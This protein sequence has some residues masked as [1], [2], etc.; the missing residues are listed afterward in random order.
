MGFK[1]TAAPVDSTWIFNPLERTVIN[2][3]MLHSGLEPLSALTNGSGAA[4]ALDG[5]QFTAANP[6][7]ARLQT[8]TTDTGRAGLT[9]IIHDVGGGSIFTSVI[10][11]E[12]LATVG[13]DYEVEVGWGNDQAGLEHTDGYYFRYKRSVSANWYRC[14]NDDD[15]A[16]RTDTSVAVVAD[17]YIKL[18]IKVNAARTAAEFFINGTSVGTNST[19]L[20]DAGEFL[21]GMAKIIKSAGTTSR[22]MYVDLVHCNLKVTR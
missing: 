18:Q 2:G 20:P 16:T 1:K 10:K 13:E 19:N 15:T 14:T 4:A 12:D 8:G 11:L 9:T 3:D 6:G 5:N 7:V 17:A 22:D 21:Y